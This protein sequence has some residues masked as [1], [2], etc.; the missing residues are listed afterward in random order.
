M[1]N[2][3][4]FIVV[5]T[6]QINAKEVNAFLKVETATDLHNSLLAFQIQCSLAGY[7]S[8]SKHVRHCLAAASFMTMQ[9]RLLAIVTQLRS[10][11]LVAQCTLYNE[12]THHSDNNSSTIRIAQ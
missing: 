7:K 8:V 6:K 11:P 9:E 4:L 2:P 12:S 3:I 10:H 1:I 5:S